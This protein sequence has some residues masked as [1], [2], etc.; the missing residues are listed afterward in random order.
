MEDSEKLSKIWSTLMRIEQLQCV[1]HDQVL[2]LETFK[3]AKR[4]INL[5][6]WVK[7]GQ[8]VLNE[9]IKY[10]RSVLDS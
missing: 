8:I 5:V 1:M 2:E 4:P 3:M 6:H 10:I 7:N 9:D